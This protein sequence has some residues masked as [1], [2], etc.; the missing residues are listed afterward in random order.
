MGIRRGRVSM[1]TWM[2]AGMLAAVAGLFAVGAPTAG[3]TP[4]RRDRRPQRPAGGDP[5]RARLDRRSAGEGLQVGIAEAM[6]A[7]YQ[8][9]I[10]FL[11]RGIGDVVP[12]RHGRRAAGATVR[13]LRHEGDD[14]C[15]TPPPPPSTG[16]T[17]EPDAAGPDPR[18]LVR[19]AL[20]S[21]CSCRPAP[22]PALRRGVLAADR[23]RRLRRDH[24]CARAQPPGRHDRSALAR[25]CVLP[26]GR[27]GDLHLRVGAPGG[28]ANPYDGL[29][30]PPLVG[31]VLGVRRRRYRR[32]RLQPDRREVE[33]D[34]PRHRVARPRL[35]RHARAQHLDHVTGGFNGRRV[36]G[37]SLF[38]SGSAATT[39]REL[40]GARGAL[41][42]VRAALVPRSGPVHRGLLVRV[43]P[44]ALPSR[45]RTGD[46]AR[47]RGGGLGHGGQRQRLQGQGVPR[48]VDV[49]RARGGALRAVHRFDRPGLVRA[50]VVG[51]VP[52]DDR[53]GRARFGHR[54]NPGG[55]R[56]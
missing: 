49:R 18:T 15:L 55:A 32:P 26:G 54:R 5:R 37:F 11:G 4:S 34:L 12:R 16:P 31:M 9:Q 19:A 17:R 40:D 6:A 2:I 1:F 56:S 13:P 10:A 27:R 38:G 24:R 42:A 14:P 22:A 25:P 8:D 48:L 23:V 51:A 50:H 29:E 3:V 39:S 21:P 47:Q 41:R 33:R 53:G 43:Q 46:P 7:G 36:P 20:L 28:T 52:R 30:L 45:A 44:R 35:H